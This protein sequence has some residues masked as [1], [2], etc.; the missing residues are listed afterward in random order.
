M[1]PNNIPQQMYITS[2]SLKWFQMWNTGSSV[3][4]LKSF[5]HIWQI[6]VTLG[7]LTLRHIEK[8]T[9]TAHF[10]AGGCPCKMSLV[11]TAWD[12]SRRGITIHGIMNNVFLLAHFNKSSEGSFQEQCT[13]H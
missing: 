5:K 2:E 9:W 4:S 11:R 13:R 6:L 1:L 8:G 7:E 3:D 10:V 12:T